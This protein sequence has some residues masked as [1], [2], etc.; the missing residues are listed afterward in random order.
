MTKITR[1][2]S[3]DKCQTEIKNI[4]PQKQ[5]PTRQAEKRRQKR[6]NVRNQRSDAYRETRGGLTETPKV[7]TEG[8]LT[9]K[10]ETED[11]REHLRSR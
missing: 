11:R 2:V 7:S 10:P 3:I 9:L 4:E 1:T 5:K 8:K 6:L